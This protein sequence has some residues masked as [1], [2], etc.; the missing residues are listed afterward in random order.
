M[1]E[2]ARQIIPRILSIPISASF[3]YQKVK[4]CIVG[5]RDGS[6][7]TGLFRVSGLLGKKKKGLVK[8]VFRKRH[9]LHPL[10]ITEMRIIGSEIK[11]GLEPPLIV[12]LKLIEQGRRHPASYVRKS[13]CLNGIWREENCE[14]NR[15]LA[16]RVRAYRE[17]DVPHF[18]R[19]KSFGRFKNGLVELRLMGDTDG[20][21]HNLLLR[22]RCWTVIS[23]QCIP[24]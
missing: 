24:G 6:P 13:G 4:E 1:L 3:P 15:G 12:R 10:R 16:V 19:V 17:S 14:E 7:E 21:V 8:Q 5:G 9:R 23:L 20:S 22:V 2:C 11:I 18:P